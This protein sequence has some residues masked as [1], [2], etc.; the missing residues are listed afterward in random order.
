MEGEIPGV[1]RN[2]G[3]SGEASGFRASIERFKDKI[4]D[5]LRGRGGCNIGRFIKEKLNPIVR[6]RKNHFRLSMVKWIFEELDGWTRR[7]LRVIL[8]RQ[9]KRTK[10]R[11]RRLMG[12]GM[13]E[14]RAWMSAGNQRGAWWNAGAS[15]MN[16]AF[17]MKYVRE[18][19]LVELQTVSL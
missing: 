15:H 17:P 12:R 11:A 16:E 2:D 5:I 10:T 18:L 9:M 6:G 1:H 3:Q 7:R 19:G 13:E 8:W 4:R 14:Q